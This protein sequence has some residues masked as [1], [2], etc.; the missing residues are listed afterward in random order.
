MKYNNKIKTSYDFND[1]VSGE[2]NVYECWSFSFK[3]LDKINE[4]ENVVCISSFKNLSQE[5]NS[6]LR[7]YITIGFYENFDLFKN[8]NFN[9]FHP[10]DFFVIPINPEGEYKIQVITDIRN[11]HQF[12]VQ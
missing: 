11:K 1:H 5:G 3:D 2:E 12:K 8:E 6:I 7:N 10:T 4:C 9:G